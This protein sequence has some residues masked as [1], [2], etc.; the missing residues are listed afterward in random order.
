MLFKHPYGHF[1]VNMIM[2]VFDETIYKDE[3][4]KQGKPAFAVRLLVQGMPNGIF[5]MEGYATVEEADDAREA[6]LAFMGAL[7]QPS[8][9]TQ[10]AC[11]V[12][13]EEASQPEDV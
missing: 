8:V 4:K 6:L 2:V 11:D 5:D 13:A 12:V 3:C 1:N 10:S 9:C 7:E